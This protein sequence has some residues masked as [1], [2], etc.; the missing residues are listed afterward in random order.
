MNHNRIK[1]IL[2]LAI[3]SCII[4]SCDK[5]GEGNP[6]TIDGLNY[7]LYSQSAVI[8]WGNTASG[9]LVIPSEVNYNGKK[10]IVK[11]M[12]A[13]AFTRCTELTKVIIPKTIDQ[14]VN[15]G[16][17]GMNGAISPD[18]MNPFAGCTAL[19]KDNPIMCSVDG[20]LFSKDKTRL[21]AYPAGAKR[22][23]YTIPES[24]TWIGANAFAVSQ[25]LS[26]LI[27]RG[28]VTGYIPEAAFT[29]MNATAVIYVQQ[30]EIE[31]FQKV[32]PGTVL[33][34]DSFQ[35]QVF[36][37]SIE[38]KGIVQYD[39]NLSIWTISVYENGAIDDVSLY[40]PKSLDKAFQ[41]NGLPITVSGSVYK[42]S[43][44]FLSSISQLGG[45]KYY[46]LDITSISEDSLKTNDLIGTWSL[47]KADYHFGGVKTFSPDEYVYRFYNNGILVVQDLK[48]GADSATSIFMSAGTHQYNLTPEN[49]E[50]T[51]DS[52]T[53]W[54]RFDNG[55]LIIDCGSAWDAPVFVFQK[56]E[57]KL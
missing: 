8:D 27:F 20:V 22:E 45:Y 34:L 10:Y 29:G 47:L 41:K 26:T 6:V 25:N 17:N 38:E 46:A 32:F 51:I 48:D 37:K 57:Y 5:E 42:L 53:A 55:N 35:E 43:D 24:V 36:I 30:S 3:L 49:Q 15:H 16:F 21:Y 13:G 19:D 56:S 28:T 31:K 11:G 4:F 1:T 50:I 2:A 12:A 52:S 9:V 14:I 7:Y 44:T 33:P 54:Y 23:S 18:Y 40:F 39:E